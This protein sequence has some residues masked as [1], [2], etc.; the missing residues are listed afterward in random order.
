MGLSLKNKIVLFLCSV[1]ALLLLQECNSSTEQVAKIPEKDTANC[2]KPL[3]PNGDSELAVLM[4][5]MY[6]SAVTFQKLVKEGRT[7][8]KLPAAFLKIHTA[9]PTDSS[10]VKDPA[11]TSFANDYVK[12]L[13]ALYSSSKE[14]L[15]S[16]YNIMLDKC[17]NCHQAYCPGPIKKI[18]KLKLSE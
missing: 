9:K 7:D 18:N 15:G 6:D 12:G 17:V 5:A 14:E 16:N 8:V 3:N 11:Y 1:T 10:A 4:R 2:E 13:N